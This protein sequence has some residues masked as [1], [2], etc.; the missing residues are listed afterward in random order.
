MDEAGKP[1][2]LKLLVVPDFKGKTI[3]HFPVKMSLGRKRRK[4]EYDAEFMAD[5]L[6]SSI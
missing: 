6:L 3:K 2:H 1:K 5:V 4:C